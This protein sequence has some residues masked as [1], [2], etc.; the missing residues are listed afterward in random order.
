MAQVDHALEGGRE[1]KNLT[2]WGIGI[3]TLCTPRPMRPVPCTTILTLQMHAKA[4]LVGHKTFHRVL[5]YLDWVFVGG[6]GFVEDCSRVC[7]N[8][9]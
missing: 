4:P 2:M 8:V 5:L 6:R 3:G 1:Y 7:S 9:G